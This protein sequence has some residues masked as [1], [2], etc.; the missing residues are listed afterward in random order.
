[1]RTCEHCHSENVR[2]F[3]P[4]AVAQR[5]AVLLCMACQRLTIVPPLATRSRRAAPVRRFPA[6]TRQAA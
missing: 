4:S 1:M 6:E 2:W 3:T 5:A